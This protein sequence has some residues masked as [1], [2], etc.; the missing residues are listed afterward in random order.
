MGAAGAQSSQGVEGTTSIKGGLAFLLAIF[1]TCSLVLNALFTFSALDGARMLAQVA[2]EHGV[3]VDRLGLGAP[4]HFDAVQARYEHTLQGGLLYIFE[5][6]G[7]PWAAISIAA[8]LA[9]AWMWRRRG[10]LRALA[11]LGLTIAL[12]AIVFAHWAAVS[13]IGTWMN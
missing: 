11:P 2:E 6:M 8:A 4:E 7:Q 13:K 12:L 3:N 10:L 1:V 5:W 9:L